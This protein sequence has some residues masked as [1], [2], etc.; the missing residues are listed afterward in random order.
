VDYALATTA[1]RV[2]AI[3]CLRCPLCRA[4]SLIA[5]STAPDRMAWSYSGRLRI[6]SFLLLIFTVQRGQ[7]HDRNVAV[8]RRMEPSAHF[9]AIGV[10]S[11]TSSTI[12]MAVFVSGAQGAAPSNALRRSIRDLNVCADEFV[13]FRIVLNH[14]HIVRIAI[15]Q[16]SAA[17][18]STGRLLF[19]TRKTASLRAQS[20][21]R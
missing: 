12:R 7:E 13:D 21:A 20:R 15:S 11:M 10:G 1:A 9:E 3:I 18:Y 17:S 6:S 5:L 8:T 4:S 14:Q 16:S 19:A 2:L